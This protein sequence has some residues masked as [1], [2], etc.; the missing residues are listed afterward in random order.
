M[1]SEISK[2]GWEDLEVDKFYNYM[3]EKTSWVLTL[4]T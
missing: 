2:D 3:V 1:L 4:K